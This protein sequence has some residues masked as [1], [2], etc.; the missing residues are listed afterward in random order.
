LT[1]AAGRATIREREI[2]RGRGE[3]PERRTLY[4]WRNKG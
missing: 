1:R 4:N 3:C 2:E